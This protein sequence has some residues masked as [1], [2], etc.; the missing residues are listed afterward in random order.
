MNALF[1]AAGKQCPGNQLRARI[2]KLPSTP[3]TYLSD[4]LD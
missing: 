4:T 3:L 1:E 2:A